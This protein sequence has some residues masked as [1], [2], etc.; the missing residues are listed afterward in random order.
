MRTRTQKRRATP[1]LEGLEQRLALA[2]GMAA[3]AVHLSHR[4]HAHA[5]PA[6]VKDFPF[7][8]PILPEY[9]AIQRL[10][11]YDSNAEMFEP[12]TA[13]HT[14]AN[15]STTPDNVYVISHGWAP[16]YLSWVENIQKQ[17]GNPLPLSWNT[18]QGA[19]KKP[20]DGPTTPWLFKASKTHF[21]LTSFT[22]SDTGLAQ[23]ILA[24]D[25]Q[26]TVVAY[27]WIDNSAT[28]NG[29]FGIPKNPEHSQ[30]YTTMNGM[31]MA[32]AI[33]QALAPDYYQGLG[34]VHLIGHSHG[35][36]VAT[37][38]A[39][40][41]Q[42]AGK[43]SPQFDVVG[44]LTLF[45][46]PENNHA[47][48]NDRNPIFIDAANYDW[49]LLA[50]LDIARN[51]TMPGSIAAGQTTLTIKDLPAREPNV[52]NLVN[53]MVVTGPGISSGTT[54]TSVNTTTRQVSLSKPAQQSSD[55]YF[56]FAPPPNSIFVDS[57]NS[58]F[59]SDLGNFVVND[60]AQ[61]LS[62][63]HLNNLV[64][65]KLVALNRAYDAFQ[66]SAMHQYAANWYAGSS[67]TKPFSENSPVGIWWSPLIPGYLRAPASQWKQ[68]WSY[69]GA[70]AENQ[71]KIKLDHE[72]PFTPK[73]F[74]TALTSLKSIGEVTTTTN[75]SNQVTAVTLSSALGKV[76]FDGKVR[77]HSG[78]V[79][80][81]SFDTN[82][83]QLG[84]GSQLQIL[85][86]G[87][88]YFAMSGGVADTS[89]L[90]GNA[91][92]RTTFGLATQGNEPK[93]T[94]RLVQPAD[95]TG[96]PTVVTVSNFHEFTD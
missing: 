4:S 17:K 63:K 8:V 80:G 87:N 7:Q 31:R 18:W 92:F 64:D 45:D 38:A 24:V 94:M 46:S 96:S 72:A 77:K 49:F 13:L 81:F 78:G 12:F 83:T 73:F 55:F 48:T 68:S 30:A 84:D 19:G 62:N 35:A 85:L 21:G 44:Q 2:G 93:I 88:V 43:I 3:A 16:G 15:S 14:I 66:F 5:I 79:V 26:A 11:Y 22:I 90:P 86:N 57:Y 91:E 34:K 9:P 56:A 32:E 52:S 6:A 76:E 51:V 27:S 1:A 33:V 67:V 60:P 10:A 42:Q 71:F 36:R 28:N 70:T 37:E 89:D 58:Y 40:A 29:T 53:G 50:Q 47:S 75:A 95:S 23:K 61:G 59:G 69:L 20:S 54:I 65:V 74:D 41:L 39:L 82:F 25:P